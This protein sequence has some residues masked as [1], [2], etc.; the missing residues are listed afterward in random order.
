MGR[1][2]QT[3]SVHSV[4]SKCE[5]QQLQRDWMFVR[6]NSDR[7]RQGP[8]DLIPELRLESELLGK[9]A[10]AELASELS[11]SSNAA[12]A[13]RSPLRLEALK[14]AGLSTTGIDMS[15][16]QKALRIGQVSATGLA[17]AIPGAWH[18]LKHDFTPANWGQTGKKLL[19][20][21]VL[22]ATM[23][24]VMP[25][26]A[27]IS[28][29][30]KTAVTLSFLQDVAAPVFTAWKDVCSNGSELTMTRSARDLGDKL[31]AFMLDAYLTGV[32]A[33]LAGRVT[34]VLAERYWPGQWAAIESWKKPFAMEDYSTGGRASYGIGLTPP[35]NKAFRD[36]VLDATIDTGHVFGYLRDETGRVTDVISIGPDTKLPFGTIRYNSEF[37]AG[38]IPAKGDWPITEPIATYEW[39]I[40]KAGF[41]KAKSMIQDLRAHPPMYMPIEACPSAPVKIGRAL[42]LD[43]PS[44][45]SDVY[46]TSSYVPALP[47]PN[48]DGLRLQLK[49]LLKFP[50]SASAAEFQ[51]INAR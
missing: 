16:G 21:G 29:I 18:A 11:P 27:A 33:D 32:V 5:N 7:S 30:A 13:T 35:E 38:L 22:G 43:I 34:P 48:P 37:L 1:S 42:G 46:I 12:K 6:R 24:V 36:G 8:T 15:P 4:Q 45:V 17:Y 50:K 19:A 39:P 51:S 3:E 47:V 2:E 31:G 25:E 10:R 26:S 14:A 20:A 40:N 28:S 9:G 23:R 49:S 41:L 44:G